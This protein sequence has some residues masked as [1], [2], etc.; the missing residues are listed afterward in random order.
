MPFVTVGRLTQLCAGCD[1]VCASLGHHRLSRCR[2]AFSPAVCDDVGRAGPSWVGHL[3][4]VGHQTL[5]GRCSYSLERVCVLLWDV[6][7]RG[8]SC[9]MVWW[10]HLC[11]PVWCE[12]GSKQ[13]A[14]G[15]L[16]LYLCRCLCFMTHM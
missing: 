11:T 16:S 15:E 14:C 6:G 1:V 8:V 7:C 13:S 9:R 12:C 3:A 4:T 5:L 10:P 2:D